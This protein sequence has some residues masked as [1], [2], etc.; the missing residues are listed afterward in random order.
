VQIAKR[1]TP[2]P[3]A[4]W[5]IKHLCEKENI[6]GEQN[7]SSPAVASIIRWSRLGT[8]LR[9]PRSNLPSK[10]FIIRRALTAIRES[11][12]ADVML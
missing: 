8:A 11:A 10:P 4:I 7:N 1:N 3:T 6:Q 12:S 5:G 9:Y 2:T